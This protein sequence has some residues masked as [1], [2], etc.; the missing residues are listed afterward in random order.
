[1]HRRPPIPVIPMVQ[2]SPPTIDPQKPIFHH[3]RNFLPF[4]SRTNAV[5]PV[6]SR[7]PLDVSATLPLPS[8]LSGQAATR[9]E[10][11]EIDSPPPPSNAPVSHFL[12]Q[13]LSFLMPRHSH[14]PPVV[15]V[16]PGRKFTRLLAAKLPEYR[17]EHDT[18]HPPGQ[19]AGVPQDIDS[20]DVDSLPD[21]HWCKAFL[22]Y[23]SCWSHGSLRM[24]P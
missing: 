3:L 9:F 1:M 14:G 6:Q 23:C 22:C 8:S 10:R 18:R 11:F 5:R 12:R 15:E 13:H 7:N 24:P 20:S 4:S 2:R 17:K 16:A 21:V 19:Q